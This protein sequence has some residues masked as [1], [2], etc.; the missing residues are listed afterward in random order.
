MCTRRN[1]RKVRSCLRLPTGDSSRDNS[2]F[3]NA[4]D[5]GRA[6][7]RAA[8]ARLQPPTAAPVAT[9]GCGIRGGDA[10]V[11]RLDVVGIVL[12][13]DPLGVFVSMVRADGHRVLPA[14]AS[15]SGQMFVQARLHVKLWSNLVGYAD[16]TRT[17]IPRS[18]GR[19]G[20]PCS[21][22][23]GL[24]LPQVSPPDAIRSGTRGPVKDSDAGHPRSDQREGEMD[25]GTE[26]AVD[27][28]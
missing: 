14:F 6:P 18:T 24:Q 10:L 9:H 11:A 2:S 3:P 8:A 13:Q 28:R 23:S 27:G 17:G 7:S 20:A 22:K 1:E 19:V 12:A 4:V 15:P 26:L 5:L 25:A 21:S 16:V